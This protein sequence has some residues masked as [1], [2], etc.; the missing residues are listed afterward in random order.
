MMHVTGCR[1]LV[2]PFKIEEQDEMF[3]RAQA[4]GIK[5][6]EMEERKLQSLIDRGTVVQIGPKAH[7]DY[8]EG[9]VVGD[10]IGFT[11][12]GGKF[13]KDPDT[14]EEMLVIN[15]EDVLVVFKENT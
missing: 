2:K 13:I 9:L 5:I 8:V 4:L 1:V 6:P 12:F 10:K 3:K 7:E 14:N 11:K 15:D